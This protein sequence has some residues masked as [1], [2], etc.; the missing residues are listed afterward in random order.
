M[1]TEAQK[2]IIEENQANID[3]WKER[4]KVVKAISVKSKLLGKDFAFI[5]GKPTPSVMDAV[6]SYSANGKPE[7]VDEVLISSCVLAGDTKVFQVDLD[8]KNAVMTKLMDLFEKLQVEE[9][10]L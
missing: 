9:K 7:K 3:G 5:I 2:T 8:V 10:E 4:H 6:A 1:Q